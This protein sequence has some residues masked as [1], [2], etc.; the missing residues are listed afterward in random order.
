MNS[1]LNA[2]AES[3]NGN[4]RNAEGSGQSAESR[5]SRPLRPVRPPRPLRPP[6]PLRPPL[7]Y[8][9]APP[10]LTP[11]PWAGTPPPWAWPPPPPGPSH[12]PP[13]PAER[14]AEPKG[15]DLFGKEFK[16]RNRNTD[17]VQPGGSRD[18]RG[19]D[20]RDRWK[21]KRSRLPLYAAVVVFGAA[22]IIALA[23]W[24][25]PLKWPTF[26][27]PGQTDDTI[28]SRESLESNVAEATAPDTF[29]DHAGFDISTPAEQ[30]AWR[31][32][33][34]VGGLDLWQAT[35]TSIFSGRI[36]SEHGEWDFQMFRRI[37]NLLKVD[38]TVNNYRISTAFD[39]KNAW[40]EISQGGDTLNVTEV[41]Q[42]QEA[43]MRATARF[44]NPLIEYFILRNEGRG[45]AES[46]RL[47]DLGI[48]EFQGR[49]LRALQLDYPGRDERW[50]FYLDPV[51]Y[52]MFASQHQQDVMQEITTVYT[53]YFF[54]DGRKVAGNETYYFNDARINNMNITRARFNT[55][56]LS[57]IFSRS[58]PDNDSG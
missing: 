3:N 55:G 23:V 5:P 38:I 42:T 17:S 14:A 8:P 44:L 11:P 40:R 33:Q 49:R 51:S 57:G 47:E 18:R 10:P 21:S 4:G 16:A 56:L 30:V 52:E 22:G 34:S 54:A 31:Y 7:G 48:R 45:Y 43:L 20:S 50:V 15:R 53:D 26:G 35:Q 37:P 12:A 13:N 6:H 19:K 9:A 24:L 27:S 41:D 29:S 2:D 58:I 25:H 39:G 1:N 28:A 36:E 46:G 32:V